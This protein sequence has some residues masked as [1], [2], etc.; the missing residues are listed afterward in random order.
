M[1]LTEDSLWVLLKHSEL[2]I[3]S[4]YNYQGHKQQEH[5]VAPSALSNNKMEPQ[6][7]KVLNGIITLMTYSRIMLL[8]TKGDGS[9]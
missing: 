9:L 4:S 6:F 2:F 7:I 3:V 8:E 1:C 5:L